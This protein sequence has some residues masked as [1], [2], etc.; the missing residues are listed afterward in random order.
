MAGI[1]RV[2]DILGF[3][4]ILTAPFSPDVFVNGRPVALMGCVYTPHPPCGVPGQEFHCVGPTLGIPEGVLI[5]GLPPI[6]KGSIG[7]CQDTVKTASGDVQIAGGLLSTAV[8]LAA[9]A[10]GDGPPDLG[11]TAVE[12][13]GLDVAFAVMSG[14]DPTKVLTGAVLNIAGKELSG[15]VNKELVGEGINKAAAEVAAQ[16]ASAGF[17]AAATG[18]NIGG[19]VV[20]AGVGAGVNKAAGEI[21]K[22]VK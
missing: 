22:V 17:K 1:A 11:L 2:G 14:E 10:F 13:I 18:Q 8:G 9:G 7:L 19:A 5:N 6:T 15:A 20:S 16:V 21:K 3:G 12:K 4:G